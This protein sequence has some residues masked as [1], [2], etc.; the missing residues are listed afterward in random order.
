[1]VRSAIE[2]FGRVCV[3]EVDWRPDD[4]WN[5]MNTSV[6]VRYDRRLPV[7]RAVN[8]VMSEGVLQIVDGGD[9]L[10]SYS[11]VVEFDA[12]WRPVRSTKIEDATG[13]LRNDDG[14]R[15]HGF[16]DCRLWHDGEL[17][18]V[19]A[20]VRAMSRETDHGCTKYGS[21]EMAI[22]RL[23]NRW[24]TVSVD[25]VRDYQHHLVQK[26][27]MPVVGRAGTFVYQCGDPTIV[28]ARV[29]G[30]TVEVARSTPAVPVAELRGSSQVI[31]HDGGWLCVTHEV[32]ES[33]QRRLYLHRFV[34]LDRGYR[35]VA[36]SEPFFFARPGVEFCCG[37]TR[38][39]DHIIASFSVDDGHPCLAFFEPPRVDCALRR[40]E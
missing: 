23:D 27:W 28:V 1:M 29:S 26:N 38:D 21:S 5:P 9:V 12:D 16:E 22:M 20:S 36:A 3:R 17:Y 10:R 31:A 37:L 24:R 7:I 14:F 39:G 8:Y 4:G 15:A 19:S 13:M 35:V 6:H 2:A 34:R 18:C 30:E 32:A 40:W 33:G 25:V 11:H